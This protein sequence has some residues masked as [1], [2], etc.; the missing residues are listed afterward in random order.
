MRVSEELAACKSSGEVIR[1]V[2]KAGQEELSR[3]KKGVL[4]AALEHW[5]EQHLGPP[6]K[7]GEG[8]GPPPGFA[9]AVGLEIAS[10]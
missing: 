6:P 9:L 2:D 8:L 5:V 1:V 10:G 4:E 7:A 3:W